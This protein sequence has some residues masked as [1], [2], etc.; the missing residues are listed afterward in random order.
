MFV[1]V[2]RWLVDG[3]V[4]LSS[5]VVLFVHKDIVFYEEGSLPPTA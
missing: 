5:V 2:M 4:S 3:I 1:L